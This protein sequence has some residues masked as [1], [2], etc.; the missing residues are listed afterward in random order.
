MASEKE[1]PPKER[2]PDILETELLRDSVPMDAKERPP[3]T[4]EIENV[5]TP[6]DE[7]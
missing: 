6:S 1:P 7:G 3:D 5:K 4:I 2:P